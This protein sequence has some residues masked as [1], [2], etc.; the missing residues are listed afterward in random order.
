MAHSFVQ[1]FNDER[2]AFAAFAEVYPTTVLLVNT[3][4]T[5]QGVRHAIDLARRI[6]DDCRLTGVRL[7]SGDLDALAKAGA[8]IDIFGVGTEMS[9]AADAPALDIAYKPTE[10]AES[11]RM[12]KLSGRKVTTPG[13]KQIFRQT[14][15]GVAAPDIVTRRGE[16][17]EGTPLVEPVMLGGEPLKEHASLAVLRDRATA[18]IASLPPALRMLG[19]AAQ[20]YPVALSDRLQ[21]DDDAL[22]ARLNR[23]AGDGKA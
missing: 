15:D 7:D 20:G 19:K 6:G 22:G 2:E 14:A 9:V 11:G 10:F 13:R 8:L 1:P 18:M 16:S 21:D 17:H 4:D 23:A 12:K 5:P 3:Y